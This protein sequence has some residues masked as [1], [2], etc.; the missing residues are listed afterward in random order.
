[1]ARNWEA[2]APH[3]GTLVDR[4][5]RGVLKE[6]ALERAAT[7]R[8]V[9]LNPMAVCDLELIATGAFSPLTGFMGRADYE[10]VLE[11][12]RLSNGL[13]PPK[14]NLARV[15][16]MCMECQIESLRYPVGC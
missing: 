4:V 14:V 7:L 3:G 16:W 12:M 2:I 5:I 6:A 13:R 9:R 1:M 15:V 8:A 11:E 10:D